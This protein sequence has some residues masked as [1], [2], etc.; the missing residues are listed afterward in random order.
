MLSVE[1]SLDDAKGYVLKAIQR[2]RKMTVKPE[3]GETESSRLAKA[4]VTMLTEIHIVVADPELNEF[5][6]VSPGT[7][8]HL[9][10][11]SINLPA[12]AQEAHEGME[13]MNL[14]TSKYHR[15]RLIFFLFMAIYFFVLSPVL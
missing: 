8:Y 12:K 10:Q 6:D 14:F 1:R 11:L 13:T 9:M 2:S 7:I 4:V 5:A 15:K 3:N